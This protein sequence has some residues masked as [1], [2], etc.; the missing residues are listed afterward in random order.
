MSGPL[1]SL[2]GL[3]Q[4][5]RQSVMN[6]QLRAMPLGGIEHFNAIMG[7]PAATPRVE[8]PNGGIGLLPKD[9]MAEL[10]QADS[11]PERIDAVVQSY[12]ESREQKMRPSQQPEWAQGVFQYTGFSTGSIASRNFSQF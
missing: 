4:L 8:L 10:V 12:Q 7:R 5:Q 6:Q 11:I 2:D 3:A 9:L 1:N